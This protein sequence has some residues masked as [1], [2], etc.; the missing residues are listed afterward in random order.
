[1]NH[2]GTP[3]SSR[4]NIMVDV[5][6]DEATLSKLR[7]RSDLNITVTAVGTEDQELQREHDPKMLA[8]QDVLFC[9][10]LPSNHSVMQSLRLVQIA[11]AGYGQ[12]LGLDLPS[13][14]IRAC[15]ASG[16]FDVAIAEWNVS[17]MVNL[18]RNLR[19]MIRNQDAG[20][21]I[22]E[23]EFE[24]EIRGT[25]VGLWG[26][27]GLARQTARICQAFGQQVWVLTRD[28]VRERPNSFVVPGT[29]DVEGCLPDRVFTLDQKREF[30]G[31]LDYLIIALPLNPSTQGMIGDEELQALPRHAMLL[32]P[33]RGPLIRED[34]LLRALREGWIRGAALDTHY[35][36]PMPPEHPLW[37]MPNV[38]M[39]PHISGSARGSYFLPRLWSI[40]SQNID[41]LISGKPLMNELTENQLRQ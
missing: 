31:G 24:S 6:I 29:G 19:Q 3:V 1:V 37:G 15:N 32:N 33:A 12:L 35:Y 16:V 22:R 14:G 9:S 18:T 28:G 38:I 39:T 41:R 7:Q 4:L 10:Y 36:Y 8:E 34:S 2:D 40:F 5:L 25:T 13:R 21:W 30:L 23:P 17:M 26:Y 11:S 27:G 20:K